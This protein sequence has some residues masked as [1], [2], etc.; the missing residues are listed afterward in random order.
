VSF[1]CHGGCAM[2]ERESSVASSA[3]FYE[4]ESKP[5]LSAPVAPSD[6][7]ATKR[8]AEDSSASHDKKRKLA[9]PRTSISSDLGWCAGLPPAVWQH[10]FLSCSLKDLGRLMQ[11]NRSFLLYLTDVH[12]VSMSKADA[13]CLRLLKSE[14]VWAS[15]RNAHFP[16]PPKPLPG[17]SE[18][19]MWQLAWSKRCQFCNKASSSIPGEKIWQKG[20]G[21]TGVRTVWPFG[22]RACGPCLMENCQT[23]SCTCPSV[24][25]N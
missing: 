25:R 10:I 18:R 2:D 22:T 11:V 9:S 17:F 7:A 1:A 6:M 4:S 16:K 13:G 8:K 20:P 23:V 12:N 24:D 15:A 5:A 3:D 19:Q 14:S 21:P